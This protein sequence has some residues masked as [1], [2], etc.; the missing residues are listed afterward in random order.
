MPKRDILRNILSTSLQICEKWN[1]K[2]EIIPKFA[3]L[4]QIG[5]LWKQK[6]IFWIRFWLRLIPVLPALRIPAEESYSAIDGSMFHFSADLIPP[7][8]LADSENEQ[9]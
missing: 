4:T 1:E 9:I 8:L 7:C 6:C 2:D 3:D 5:I